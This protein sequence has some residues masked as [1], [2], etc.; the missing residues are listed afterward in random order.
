MNKLI[1]ALL[2]FSRVNTVKT[3]WSELSPKRL[4][5]TVLTD[6][7]PELD[8]RK[9][10]VQIGDMP[11][12]LLG[13]ETRLRQLFQNLF[14]NALKFSREEV[15]PLIQVACQNTGKHWQFSVA[16]NGIG[17]EVEFQQRIFLLFQKLHSPQQ[18][19]G[20]GM[21]LSIVKKIV[22]QHG[23]EIWLDS[24]MSKGTCF[25][26]SLALQPDILDHKLLE[27]SEKPATD[28][29]TNAVL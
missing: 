14:T 19:E 7:R 17:V 11:E 15:V 18:Y 4:L 6:I 24:E 21:G 25:H 23:G 3:Q 29:L 9:A 12:S 5:E 13:D 16:D 20:T 22:E 27:R 2:A 1:E 28:V 8:E 26:F 10:L